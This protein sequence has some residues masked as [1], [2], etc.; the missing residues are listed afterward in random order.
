M[1]TIEGTERKPADVVVRGNA[2]GFLQEIVSGAH[3]LRADE[4]VGVGGGDYYGQSVY[5]S[6][7]QSADSTVAAVQEQLAQQGYYRGEIDG[8]FGAQTRR[9][10]VRYQSDHGLRETG[11][12]NADTLRALGL[13]RVASN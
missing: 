12:L 8:V 2:N 11:N 13:P 3:Q 10:I 5:G 1:N 9:A 6:S 7:E 4:P